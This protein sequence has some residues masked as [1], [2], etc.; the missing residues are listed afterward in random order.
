MRSDIK[1]VHE[2][3]PIKRVSGGGLVDMKQWLN[4]INMNTTVTRIPGKSLKQ[5]YRGE[6]Y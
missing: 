2:K 4:D 5:V 1:A 3:H 6:E